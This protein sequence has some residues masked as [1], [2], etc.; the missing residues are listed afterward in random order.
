ME[1]VESY[2]LRQFED[3]PKALQLPTDRPRPAR[4]SFRGGTQTAYVDAAG[5]AAIK[6]A[7]AR[8]GCTLFV[9]LL[10][11]F[12]TLVGR[13]ADQH[14]VVTGIPAAGQA[15]L[16]NGSLVGHCVDFLPVR[17]RWGPDDRLLDL[18]ESTKRRVLDAYE[19]QTYT[20]GTLVRKLAP[21]REA[22]RVPLAEVQFNL[23]RVAGRMHLPGLDVDAQPNPKAF[24]NFDVFFN[25]VESDDGLRIDC[26]YNADLFDAATIDRWLR[27]YRAVLDA[28]VEDPAVTAGAVAYAPAAD[29]VPVL[30]D[31]GREYPRDA[32]I[33]ALFEAQVAAR[34]EAPAVSC[35][36]VVLTYAELER[37]ANRL[38]HRLRSVAG[39]GAL[40]GIAVARSLDVPVALLATLKAGCAYVPLDPQHPEARLRRILAEADVAALVTSG[41]AASFAPDGV[42]V[43]DLER[44]AAELN[45]ESEAPPAAVSADALAYVIYTSGST[46]TPKGVEITHRSVVNFLC[47]M[48]AEP[49][50]AA[51]DVLLAV[52]TISFDIAALELYLP[53]TV[54]ARVAIATA[55]DT[56]DGFALAALLAN[57]GATCMQATPAT[58]RLLLEAGFRSAPGL[59]MLCGGEAL[60]RDLADALLEGGGELW[61]MYG[62]TETTIW[63]SCKRIVPGDEPIGV[64]SP[65]AN[66]QFYVLDG[67]DRIVAPGQTGQLHIGGDGVARGYFKRPELTA[68]AFVVNPFAPGRMYRTGD[69]ARA[70]PNGEFAVLGRLDEQVKL[71]GFRIELGEIESL[72]ARSGVVARA[73][74]ALRE[75]VPGSP[76][77]V[78]YVVEHPGSSVSAA[79]LRAALAD[80]LPEYMI[81][82]AWVRLDQ[83]PLTPNGKLHR[84]ALPAPLPEAE[85]ETEF[86]PPRT[87]LEAA[88]AQIWADV[89]Q[90]DRIGRTDDLLALGADSIQLFKITARANRQGI[91]LL[92]KQLLQHRTIA[93]L[94]SQLEVAET[95]C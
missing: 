19:H 47:S 79:A 28:I 72:L 75:D 67:N 22:G 65:I 33:C 42:P 9:T 50:L 94:A 62:P 41:G 12:Q 63:S 88:L 64:G 86:S 58:W 5:Y 53:L 77:L 21:A 68:G 31:T 29:R 34:P 38:A 80:D 49:G 24:V 26:D 52:T 56:R 78:G 81:P 73:A 8:A 89:L 51:D 83:L 91:S 11:A 35:G 37:R 40:V 95:A 44:H 23:E 3:V 84:A 61:N 15:L 92:A 7:G 30:T 43:I 1:R 55:D 32:S 45:G 4:K 25:V 14:D 6:K 54:G 60:P 48:A 46:G 70:L 59:K 69:L 2:W 13:L 93:R 39:E 71:R 66:T 76:Q 74:V 82:A 17:A 90:R 36:D 57:A 20:L 85:A 16:D 10:T 87:P 27:Y 18:L